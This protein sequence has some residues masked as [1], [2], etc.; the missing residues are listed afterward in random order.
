MTSSTFQRLAK[1]GWGLSIHDDLLDEIYE[2][3][4]EATSFIDNMQRYGYGHKSDSR[5]NS[6]R[7]HGEKSGATLVTMQSLRREAIFEI[8]EMLRLKGNRESIAASIDYYRRAADLGHPGAQRHLALMPGTPTK[9][10]TI[11][12]YSASLGGDVEAMLTLAHRHSQG[13]LGVPRSCEAAHAYYEAAAAKVAEE[14]EVKS[15]DKSTYL[16][17][18][19][20]FLADKDKD[21]AAGSRYQH[22]TPSTDQ[23]FE[24]YE[25]L[26]ADGNVQAQVSF[27]NLLLQQRAENTFYSIAD[28]RSLAS[29]IVSPRSS[30][31]ESLNVEDP[32][33]SKFLDTENKMSAEGDN[34]NAE[35]VKPNEEI[36]I[37]GYFKALYV[38]RK[39][40]FHIWSWMSALVG[41][42]TLRLEMWTGSS[43]DASRLSNAA[44]LASVSEWLEQVVSKYGKTMTDDNTETSTEA[45]GGKH[46]TNVE[47]TDTNDDATKSEQETGEAM[48]VLGKISLA[49]HD[50]DAALRWFQQGADRDDKSCVRELGA[51]FLYSNIG[52]RRYW[53]STVRQDFEMAARLLK[54]A[55]ALGSAWAN[56][57]LAL[58]HLLGLGPF[59]VDI[60]RAERLL[61]RAVKANIVP[62]MHLFYQLQYVDDLRSGT[63]EN[64]LSQLVAKSFGF[65]DAED[66]VCAKSVQKLKQVAEQAHAVIWRY[67]EAER[68]YTQGQMSAALL[69]FLD[70][71]AMGQI[72]ANGNAGW[73]LSLRLERLSSSTSTLVHWPSRILAPDLSVNNMIDTAE[74]HDESDGANQGRYTWLTGFIT[75]A[76]EALDLFITSVEETL[77]TMVTQI[78]TYMFAFFENDWKVLAFI[79]KNILRTDH[80]DESDLESSSRTLSSAQQAIKNASQLLPASSDPKNIVWELTL[81]QTFRHSTSSQN[82]E[83]ADSVHLNTY[84]TD[85]VDVFI[86]K[87]RARRMLKSRAQMLF[88]VAIDQGWSQGHTY[89]GD[90]FYAFA[91]GMNDGKYQT[92]TSAQDKLKAEQSQNF[93]EAT[94]QYKEAV[95]HRHARGTFNLGWMHTFGLGTYAQQGLKQDKGSM[96]DLPRL[97]FSHTPLS[98]PDLHQAEAY[99]NKAFQY[100]RMRGVT[101][102]FVPVQMA[103]YG[104]R[105]MRAALTLGDWVTQVDIL[106]ELITNLSDLLVDWNLM[107]DSHAD[108]MVSAIVTSQETLA[109]WLYSLSGQGQFRALYRKT[110]GSGSYEQSGEVNGI[111]DHD[112]TYT[113]YAQP[114]SWPKTEVKD[115]NANELR[116]NNRHG[117]TSR[118]VDN[119]TPKFSVGQ[120]IKARWLGGRTW[121]SGYV[122]RVNHDESG[123]YSSQIESM[124]Q[125]TR[126]KQKLPTYDIQYD[127][128]DV[129]LNQVESRMEALNDQPNVYVVDWR[130]WDTVILLFI[131]CCFVL[132]GL[133]IVVTVVHLLARLLLPRRLYN[134][135]VHVG[136]ATVGSIVGCAI[137]TALAIN[138]ILPLFSI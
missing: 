85:V 134:V 101:G 89:L 7:N 22:R 130:Y 117:D 136:Y 20:S 42:L 78:S 77:D 11:L 25:Y 115:K 15:L 113:A 72:N 79:K 127:D 21:E 102:A 13:G 47:S 119:P 71:A 67:R 50:H 36:N 88:E 90:L 55:N 56:Y 86:S 126:L 29:F 98:K 122:L 138:I 95:R 121:Y 4:K 61:A 91:D 100:A 70:L 97:S 73:L 58:M 137:G 1:Y 39:L 59:E 75:S 9:T 63:L 120:R 51:R 52:E 105:L 8:A 19:H 40:A 53:P 10:A 2:I 48:Y 5:T 133:T 65:G 109:V 82:E 30:H 45:S 49:F 107:S 62:A 104:L 74:I 129:E 112:A 81:G 87:D 54:R 14:Y 68:F 131:I 125:V 31:D 135:L 18:L 26:A 111:P 64:S 116:S 123:H 96:V 46:G 3:E 110:V 118:Q 27:G 80:D 34:E 12:L 93:A 92:N 38:V 103:L 28:S 17:G 106:I 57:D 66:S 84:D 108:I 43:L 41:D 114:N 124:S 44:G 69:T 33:L 83:L 35:I 37:S 99:F 6:N 132:G 16:S 128:G 23:Y 24:M 76:E 32:S 60:A 94:F